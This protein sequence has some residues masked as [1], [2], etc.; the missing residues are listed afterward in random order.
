MKKFLS[1]NIRLKVV[2]LAFA[3]GLWFFVAGQSDTEV[4]LLVPLVFKGIPKDMI[5]MSSPP[6]DV[7]VRVGGPKFIINNLSPSDIKAE[8]DLG[9]VKEG[10]NTVRL[11]AKDVTTPT[12]VGVMRIRP[13]SIDVRMES[14]V[15][16][17]LPVKVRLEGR[18]APG[19]R[20]AEVT[21]SPRSVK[22]S[23]TKKDLKSMNWVSTKP[24]D[25]SG[26]EAT[27]HFTAPLD[28]PDHELRSISA[29][30]VAVQVKIEPAR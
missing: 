27:A 23:G 24:V 7:E 1:T 26:L 3:I 15:S 28:I 25:I 5:M 21:A 19:F 2:A 10:L 30:T 9:G 18:P 8:I 16:V 12:G 14:L 20:V 13:T 22:A 11:A 4:G 17:T 29:E 6:E